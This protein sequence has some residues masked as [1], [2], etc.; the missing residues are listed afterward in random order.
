[1]ELGAGD[2]DAGTDHAPDL[3]EI[4]FGEQSPSVIEQS[5]MRDPDRSTEQCVDE[6][7]RLESPNAVRREVEARPRRRPRRGT[8]DDFRGEA[9]LSKRSPERE[10]A[11]ATTDN[12]NAQGRHVL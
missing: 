7:Q 5:L 12:E 2:P 6:A 3:R 9:L 11:D 8:L 1:M 10:A 4:D